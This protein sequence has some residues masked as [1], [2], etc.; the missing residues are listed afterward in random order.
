MARLSP[1]RAGVPEYPGLER[2]GRGKVR[3]MHANSQ[4]PDVLIPVATDGLS[5]FDFVL[6]A[7][8]P[9]KGKILNAMNH[10]WMKMLEGYGIKTHLVAAGRD[11]I[12]F[13]PQEL[14][15]N[16]DF[17]ARATVVSREAVLPVEFI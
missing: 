13:L 12:P 3:D 11:M 5:I 4:H 2:V 7:L 17:L 14:Q 1:A 6:N 8:V 10:F 15:E 9:E 16:E